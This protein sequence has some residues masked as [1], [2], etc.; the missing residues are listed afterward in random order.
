MLTD[1]RISLQPLA[2]ESK[3]GPFGLCDGPSEC[4]DLEPKVPGSLWFSSAFFF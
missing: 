4:F 3:T 2:E 1:V